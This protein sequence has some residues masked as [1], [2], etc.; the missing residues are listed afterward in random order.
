MQ[1]THRL[2][3]AQAFEAWRKH[4][5]KSHDGL[6]DAIAD[7]RRNKRHKHCSLAS[8]IRVSDFRTTQQKT[9]QREQERE[10]GED[11]QP[12]IP[13]PSRDEI[14]TASR[15]R[16]PPGIGRGFE[17]PPKR[18]DDAKRKKRRHYC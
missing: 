5:A 8:R 12:L 15:G 7:E 17:D 16:L 6:K 2:K 11:S 13:R 18:N 10:R 9:S 4:D 3:R 1:I 14:K